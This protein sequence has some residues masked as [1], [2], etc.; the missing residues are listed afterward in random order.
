MIGVIIILLILI[1]VLIVIYALLLNAGEVDDLA[2]RWNE[3]L[4]EQYREIDSRR[5]ND[6]DDDDADDW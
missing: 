4:E 5:H 3:I 6:N 1:V 2:E